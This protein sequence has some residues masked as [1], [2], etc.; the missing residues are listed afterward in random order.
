MGE[1]VL[2]GARVVLVELGVALTVW[3]LVSFAFLLF[4]AWDI[5]E[6][7]GDLAS[8][9]PSPPSPGPLLTPLMYLLALGR[10]RD[11]A[12]API[13]RTSSLGRFP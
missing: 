5:R 1:L 8:W 13:S 2:R 12:A 10:L 9:L 7:G 6:R 11:P 4:W 3:L